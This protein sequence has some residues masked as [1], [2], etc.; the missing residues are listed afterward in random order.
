MHIFIS[1]LLEAIRDCETSFRPHFRILKEIR[2]ISNEQMTVADMIQIYHTLN[3]PSRQPGKSTLN[4]GQVKSTFLV[5]RWDNYIFQLSVY[6]FFS[7]LSFVVI[8]SE[9]EFEKW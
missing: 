2:I 8:A 3:T 1:C 7:C 6:V 9:L 4:D 5:V